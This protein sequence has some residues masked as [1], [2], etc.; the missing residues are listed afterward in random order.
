MRCRY[1]QG[2]LLAHAP[3]VGQAY[4]AGRIDRKAG[5]RM[6]SRED[7]ERRGVC[8]CSSW[9]LCVVRNVSAAGF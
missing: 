1:K 5:V 9:T 6:R 2:T 3:A 8:A 4:A 7:K